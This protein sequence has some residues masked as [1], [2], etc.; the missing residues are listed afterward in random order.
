[1][2]AIPADCNFGHNY[3]FV[4]VEAGILAGF[5]DRIVDCADNSMT[6]RLKAVVRLDRATVVGSAGKE[7]GSV[8]VFGLLGMVCGLPASALPGLAPRVW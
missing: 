8:R 7:G 6:T 5:V 1:M 4:E 3:P 2:A